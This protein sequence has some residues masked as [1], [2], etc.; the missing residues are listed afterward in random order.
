MGSLTI[1]KLEDLFWKTIEK[2]KV[3]VAFTGPQ[4]FQIPVNLHSTYNLSS[5]LVLVTKLLMN[6][7]QISLKL[8][9]K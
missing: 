7:F 5:L 6:Q 4:T 9:L 2:H 3:S 8:K 1:Q